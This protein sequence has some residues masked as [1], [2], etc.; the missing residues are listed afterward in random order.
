[1]IIDNNIKEIKDHIKKLIIKSFDDKEIASLT[2]S[3]KK[4][5]SVFIVN[6]SNDNELYN[7]VAYDNGVS[8][9]KKIV[10]GIVKRELMDYEEREN[11]FN[12]INNKSKA[13]ETNKLIIEYLEHF[14]EKY[15][16]II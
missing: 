15:G 7:K 5:G 10:L 4:I 9:G 1:M 16:G 13:R 11:S 3:Y 12:F 2:E 14:L 8:D 6:G